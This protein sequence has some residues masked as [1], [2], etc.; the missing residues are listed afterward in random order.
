MLTLVAQLWPEQTDWQQ[1]CAKLRQAHSLAALVVG[2]RQIG[3]EIARCLVESQLQ[4]RAAA[5][6]DWGRCP[7]CSS[8]LRSKGRQHRQV[9]TLV[10]T[11]CW[12]RP[13][14]R[15]PRHC[16]IEQVAPLDERLGIIPNQGTSSELQRL[17]LLLAVVVPFELAAELLHQLCGIAI[18]P[19]SIWNWTQQQGKT[20]QAQTDTVLLEPLNDE[21]VQLPMLLAADGITV[22]FRTQVKTTHGAVVWREVKVGLVSRYQSNTTEQGDKT[23]LHQRRLVA[24]LGDV[25][26]LALLLK[27]QALRQGWSSGIQSAWISDGAKGLW[28]IYQEQFAQGAVGILDFYHAVQHLAEAAAAYGQTLS[29]RSPEQWLARMRHQ[30]RQGYAHRIIQEL[31]KLICYDNTPKSAIPVLKQVRDYLQT[32]LA[33]VQYPKFKALNLPI[34]SGLIESACKGLIA[35]RFKGTGMR[36][37][38]DGFN[39]L[40]RLRLDWMNGRFDSS[41]SDAPP[42]LSL[43]SPNP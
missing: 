41:C 9:Q 38:E 11:V 26:A 20:A 25:D 40:L 10:G 42:V 1:T 35:Q 33:H 29:T 12:H 13:V 34:G 31:D 24:V 18:S 6:T 28:R 39:H 7:Q 23:Q 30:L 3:M 4:Q 14:G 16:P 43:Y 37:S 17:A 5:P 22:P 2:A 36:W 8:P 32:H 21:F 27:T 19:Q 15:C